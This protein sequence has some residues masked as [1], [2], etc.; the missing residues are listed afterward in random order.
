MSQLV[1]A[2]VVDQEDPEDLEDPQEA[3]RRYPSSRSITRTVAME[4]MNSATKQETVSARKK[5]VISKVRSGPF[6]FPNHN[7]LCSS[8]RFVAASSRSYEFLS[9]IA[10]DLESS[11]FAM[12]PVNVGRP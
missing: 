6:S 1:A 4:T 8:S 10:F 9:I 12:E 3:V 2:G 7:I 11:C 5:R